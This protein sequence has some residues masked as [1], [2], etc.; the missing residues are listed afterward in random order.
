MC[1]C[2]CVCVCVGGWGWR[3][4]AVNSIGKISSPWSKFY[5]VR[6]DSLMEGLHHPGKQ[7]ACH[8]SCT[9]FCVNNI[10]RYFHALHV[11]IV[12]KKKKKKKKT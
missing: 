11:N 4:E 8:E 3:E 7:A 6:V 5:S 12:E 10:E 2:V 1:V 9:Q